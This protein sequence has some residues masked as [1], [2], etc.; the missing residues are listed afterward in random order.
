MPTWKLFGSWNGSPPI[1]SI[2]NPNGKVTAT[3]Q[4][5]ITANKNLTLRR[6][7]GRAHEEQTKDQRI[8]SN[9]ATGK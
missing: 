8:S 9:L 2:E 4:K 6:T 3:K 1:A 5:K 7:I